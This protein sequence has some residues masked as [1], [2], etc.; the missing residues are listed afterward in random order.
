MENDVL[1]ISFDRG[2][3]LLRIF[4][5]E[6]YDE[7]K[8]LKNTGLFEKGT[9]PLELPHGI[10]T[11]DGYFYSI[12]G[13]MSLKEILCGEEY[14]SVKILDE[15]LV[16]ITEA[17]SQSEKLNI[18]RR[19]IVYDYATVFYQN[20]GG[21]SFVIMPGVS[22]CDNLSTCKDL[23]KTVFL[24]LSV[25]SISELAIK[26]MREIIDGMNESGDV[27]ELCE[28]INN[29]RLLLSSYMEEETLS[30]KIIKIV[31]SK[32]LFNFDIQKK[33]HKK[34]KTICVDIEGTENLTGIK[35]TKEI[36]KSFGMP[37]EI[38]VGRDKDS[39]Q[40]RIPSLFAGRNHAII[41]I[42]YDG[43]V[44]VK[45]LSKIEPQVMGKNIKEGEVKIT[46]FEGYGVKVRC[47]H[48]ECSLCSR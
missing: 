5:N 9:E 11:P 37:Y 42:C 44:F 46:F 14:I 26:N 40:I 1:N 16:S 25:E 32:N 45:A 33:L 6:A 30:D 20:F 27:S 34:E 43:K 12:K 31:K 47:A 15:L 39:S 23:I 7:Y 22:K 24:N 10:V 2:L 41:S 28:K 8:K 29:L 3:V 19:D 35:L 21:F 36:T 13:K 48:G 38:S 18:D 17:F 4:S